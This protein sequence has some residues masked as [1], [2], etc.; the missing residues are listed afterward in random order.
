MIILKPLPKQ[1]NAV[2][3]SV[4]NEYEVIDVYKRV[5]QYYHEIY[6]RF[7]TGTLCDKPHDY[8]IFVAYDIYYDVTHAINSILVDHDQNCDPNCIELPFGTSLMFLTFDELVLVKLHFSDFFRTK[9][10]Y[11][12]N[13]K[14]P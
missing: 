6:N 14:Y 5:S 4:Y 2:R 13:A 8:I 7:P 9:K 11:V 3:I 12:K 1:A 10:E